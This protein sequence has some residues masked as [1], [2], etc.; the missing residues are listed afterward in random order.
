[1]PVHHRAQVQI[2][3]ADWDLSNIAAQ[4]MVWSDNIKLAKQRGIHSGFP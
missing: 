3:V 1:M 2:S 4:D